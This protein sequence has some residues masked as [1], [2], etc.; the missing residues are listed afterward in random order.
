MRLL[1]CQKNMQLISPD[2]EIPL[3]QVNY[4]AGHHG[5]TGL[6]LVSNEMYQTQSS[7]HVPHRGLKALLLRSGTQQGLLFTR[8]YYWKLEPDQSGKK[9]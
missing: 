5:R 4:T 2:E 6:A 9:K 7:Q 3:G 1:L 8:G